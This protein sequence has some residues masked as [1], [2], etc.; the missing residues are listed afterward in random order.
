V[1][2]E[3]TKSKFRT[4]T[5]LNLMIA[6]FLSILCRAKRGSEGNED[7]NQSRCIVATVASGIFLC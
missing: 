2:I 7:E 5:V 3:E 6:F 1:F 4:A